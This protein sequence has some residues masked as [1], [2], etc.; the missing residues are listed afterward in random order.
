MRSKLSDV[1]P[2]AAKES[3]AFFSLRRDLAEDADEARQEN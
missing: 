2:L 3:P 1:V